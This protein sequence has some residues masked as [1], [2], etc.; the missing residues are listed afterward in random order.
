[1]LRMRK[2]SK[3]SIQNTGK[4]LRSDCRGEI[5][6]LWIQKQSGTALTLRMAPAGFLQMG[7]L[8]TASRLFYIEPKTAPDWVLQWKKCVE[9]REKVL[10]G[11]WRGA[12][13]AFLE[14]GLMRHFLS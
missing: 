5:L 1:M 12:L 10:G 4:F 8:L 3:L 11:T 14:D 9:E 7:A 6:A 13:Q 2:V